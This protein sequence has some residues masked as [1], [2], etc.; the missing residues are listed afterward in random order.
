MQE[1]KEEKSIH[2]KRMQKQRSQ[3]ETPA[4]VAYASAY[5]GSLDMYNLSAFLLFQDY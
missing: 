5:D 3:I 2:K 4:W 1:E